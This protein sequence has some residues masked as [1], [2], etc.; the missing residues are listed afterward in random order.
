M[1]LANW[2][3]HAC[4]NDMWVESGGQTLSMLTTVSGILSQRRES[5]PLGVYWYTIYTGTVRYGDLRSVHTVN[6]NE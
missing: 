5:L 2:L 3:I 6:P 1:I 4:M